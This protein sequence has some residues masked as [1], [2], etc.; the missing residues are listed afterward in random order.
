MGYVI[1]K[2][3]RHYTGGTGRTNT[4]YATVEE[5]QAVAVELSKTNPVGFEVLPY[6]QI[7][8]E[9]CGGNHVE[10]YHTPSNV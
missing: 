8:C 7:R 10:E 2:K 1:V 9:V 5:A 6:K 4:V 3:S